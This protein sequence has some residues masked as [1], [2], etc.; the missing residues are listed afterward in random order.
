[1]PILIQG[2]KVMFECTKLVVDQDNY[3]REQAVTM[4]MTIADGLGFINTIKQRVD[5]GEAD[6]E[7]DRAD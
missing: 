6:R 5:S 3:T 7:Q 2:A 1:M 4:M